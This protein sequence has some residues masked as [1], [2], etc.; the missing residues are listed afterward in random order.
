MLLDTAA[1]L[2]RTLPSEDEMMTLVLMA[3][4][5]QDAIM[6]AHHNGTLG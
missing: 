3:Q 5:L 1:A 2:R 4:V 6:Y